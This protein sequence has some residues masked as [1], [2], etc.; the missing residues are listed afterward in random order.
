MWDGW[1]AS[2]LSV[3]EI[4]KILPA[5]PERGPATTRP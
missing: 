4:A 5:E 1:G 3:H 2:L